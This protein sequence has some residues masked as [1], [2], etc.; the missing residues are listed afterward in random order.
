MCPP[1][2]S[3]VCTFTCRSLS[4]SVFFL[5]YFIFLSY[6]DFSAS[7]LSLTATF[8]CSSAVTLSARRPSPFVR[9]FLPASSASCLAGCQCVCPTGSM[10]LSLYS[11][12][13]SDVYVRGHR[14]PSAWPFWSTD[15]PHPPVIPSG[16]LPRPS[17]LWL[18]QPARLPTGRLCR[19]C[20][21]RSS[22][23]N[24]L[25]GQLSDHLSA[26]RLSGQLLD[27]Y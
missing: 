21:W 4:V 11:G 2:H 9:L 20:V 17:S 18:S 14:H 19:L 8:V 7:L 25:S 24:S 13:L 6:F 22:S 23:A 1:R 27:V 15:R 10:R 3:Y 26:D 5:F 16:R 12:R